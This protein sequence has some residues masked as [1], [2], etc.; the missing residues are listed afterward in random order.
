M[1]GLPMYI[2]RLSTEVNWDTEK[3]CFESFAR[4]TAIYYAKLN[5]DADNKNNWKWVIEHVFYPAVKEYLMPPK[6][7]LEN[8][9]VLQIADLPKLYKVFERC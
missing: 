6:S 7:F 3:E 4:E 8:A 2:L 9:A 1:S 5:E